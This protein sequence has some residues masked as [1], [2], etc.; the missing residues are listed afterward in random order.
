MTDQVSIPREIAQELLELAEEGRANA[1]AKVL[2]DALAQGQQPAPGMV[3]KPAPWPAPPEAT[4]GY[5]PRLYKLAT[6]K[7]WRLPSVS[8]PFPAHSWNAY[9]AQCEQ[10]ERNPEAGR[11]VPPHRSA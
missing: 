8:N 7:G 5:D 10:H 9:W 3:P 2:S 11:P 4:N 6:E 1:L